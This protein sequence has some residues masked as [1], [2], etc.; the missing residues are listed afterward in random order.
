MPVVTNLL[1]VEENIKLY[2]GDS[3][4]ETWAATDSA[5]DP[6]DLSTATVLI[7]IRKRKEP[8][9]V[10]VFEADNDAATGI[11]ISG[12]D[13]NEIAINKVVTGDTGVWF[14]DLQ[15]TFQNGRVS[16]LRAGTATLTSDVSA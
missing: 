13:N 2:H 7:Q 11:T 8:D 15:V 5:G 12:A 4:I 6:V 1:P 3:W 9:A 10:L 16:T 14:W